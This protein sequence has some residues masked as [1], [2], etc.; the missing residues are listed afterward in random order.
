[1]RLRSRSSSSWLAQRRDGLVVAV[2][3]LHM[4]LAGRLQPGRPFGEHRAA[5]E[6]ASV[7]MAAASLRISLAW[8]ARLMVRMD[9]ISGCVLIVSTARRMPIDTVEQPLPQRPQL[10]AV[11]GQ[12]RQ[13][14]VE[15]GD[16]VENAVEIALQMHRRRLGPFGAGRGH[17]DQMAGEIAAVDARHVERIERLQ[18]RRC[19]TS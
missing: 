11:V 16:A 5:R 3:V 17:G 14:L 13:A 6:F 9:A 4:R 19:R 15:D 7:S 2:R 12:L 8:T 18:R 1:M 10:P